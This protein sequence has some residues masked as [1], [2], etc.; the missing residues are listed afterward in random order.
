[1]LHIYVNTLKNKKG[2]SRWT[3][4]TRNPWMAESR[5]DPVQQEDRP[6]QDGVALETEHSD[7]NRQGGI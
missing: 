7:E 5:E 6:V 1:M 3:K 2:A 4:N